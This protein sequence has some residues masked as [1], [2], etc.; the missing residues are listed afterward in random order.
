MTTYVRAG[1]A[2]RILGVSKPTLYAYVS[3]GRVSRT[4]APDGRAS[5]F[6]L[7][8]IEA[9]AGPGRRVTAPPRPTIDVQVTSAITTLSEDGVLYRGH[10]LPDLTCSSSYEDVAELLWTGELPTGTRWRNPND[11]DLSACLGAVSHGIRPIT[12]LAIASHVLA[13]RHPNDEPPAAARR[14][15]GVTLPLLGAT[16]RTGTYAQRLTSAWRRRPPPE[17]VR[18]VDHAL[19]LLADHGLATSTLAVRVAASARTTA[20]AAT[21]AGLAA[22]DGALHGSASGVVHHFLAEC[23]QRG[24]DETTGEWRRR[25]EEFPGLGH[26][27]Y[28][29][30]DPRYVVLMEAV[31][32]VAPP[33]KVE[34][35]DGL[36]AEVGRQV[37][38][39]PNIDLALG[40][41]TWSVGLDP[42]IPLFAVARIA[43]W[44]AHCAEEFEAPPLRFRGLARRPT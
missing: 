34:L 24:I 23:E 26:K 16:R 43:G 33:A 21:A 10:S 18:A 11:E 22:V 35:V 13:D 4:T 32:R 2:A 44:A 36:V 28:R 30:S 25:N 38:H 27:V 42:D 17:L 14:L 5:L 41:L 1:E 20:H 40:A 29:R 19:V 9:L 12:R 3:R 8:E 7:D 37:P 6:A 15:L 31:R 39:Q